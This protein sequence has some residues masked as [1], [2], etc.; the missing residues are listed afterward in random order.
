MEMS[1]IFSGYQMS[2]IVPPHE[3][4]SDPEVSMKGEGVFHYVGTMQQFVCVVKASNSCC[5]RCSITWLTFLPLQWM[6]R[7]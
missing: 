1:Q 7:L 2:L 6:P 5:D 3:D 4:P